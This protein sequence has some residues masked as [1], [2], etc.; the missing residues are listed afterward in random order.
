MLNIL[1][2]PFKTNSMPFPCAPKT[3]ILQ[4]VQ[5]VGSYHDC[6]CASVYQAFHHYTCSYT[7][8]TNI[9]QLSVSGSAR[10]GH[11]NE[12]NAGSQEMDMKKSWLQFPAPLHFVCR[13]FKHAKP[14]V[15]RTNICEFALAWNGISLAPL[16]HWLRKATK[17]CDNMIRPATAWCIRGSA[18]FVCDRKRGGHRDGQMKCCHCRSHNQS[19][20]RSE[21][22][23][24]SCSLATNAES[25]FKTSISGV[26][27]EELLNCQ[28]LFVY[29]RF[30]FLLVSTRSDKP[31]ETGLQYWSI[32]NLL[33][34][35]V[36]RVNIRSSPLLSKN[37]LVHQ[38]METHAASRG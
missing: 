24:F 21:K 35:M 33:I 2:K 8:K 3:D 27:S 36:A 1:A 25:P 26:R 19:S 12:G 14:P 23:G 34:R 15:S 5:V 38:N 4:L 32:V 18:E 28:Y 10:P 17:K 31:R 7:I 30:I 9:L 22:R 16:D 11:Y 37:A 6:I 29:V 13:N 20:V